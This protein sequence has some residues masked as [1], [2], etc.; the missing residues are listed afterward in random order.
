[1]DNQIIDLNL[2]PTYKQDLA[3][4]ALNTPVMDPDHLDPSDPMYGPLTVEVFFGGGADGGK[5]WFICESRLVN[6]LR[7]PGYKSFIGRNEL[8]R[9]MQSTYVTW[10]KVCRH[11]EI[12][13]DEWRLDGQMHVIRFENGSTIDLLDLKF[14][15][16]EDPLYERFGSTEYSDGAI[17]EAGEVHPLAQEVMKSRIGRWMN[18][19]FGINP[20]L[21]ST[22]NPKK[23]WTY[24]RYYQPWVKG[25]L[26]LDRHFIQALHKDNQYGE[27]SYGKNLDRITD[28]VMRARLR[29]GDWEYE[30]DPAAL[31]DYPAIGDL[32]TNTLEDDEEDDEDGVVDGNELYM[33]VDVA[34]YGSDKTVVMMWR[35]WQVYKILYREKQGIDETEEWVK[36]LAA[37]NGIPYSHIV[38]DEDGVGG[39]VVDHMRGVRGFLANSSP[40]E[41]PE[42]EEEEDKEVLTNKP[43]QK[44]AF[45][46]LKAQCG[47]YAANKVNR[48]EAAVRTKDSQIREW[49][50]AELEQIKEDNVD[51]DEKK[52]SLVPKETVKIILGRSPDFGDAFVMRSLFDLKPPKKKQETWQRRHTPQRRG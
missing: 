29:D 28:A 6:A 24:H 21:L 40:L 20:S 51:A 37:E 26:P 41:A 8:K 22:G 30:D 5:S 38:I 32:F 3:Y 9:L 7:Y 46:N 13:R 16:S 23:N 43:Q 45:A 47:Y 42:D 52:R 35:G 50:S 36:G 15:P 44:R 1:M 25:T 33:T 4:Q 19:E 27:V 14:L 18:K 34:R 39:G 17:E 49:L 10:Q 11:H 12:P 31:I 2:Q 48:H